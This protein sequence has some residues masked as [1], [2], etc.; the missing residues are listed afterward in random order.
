VAKKDSKN[1]KKGKDKGRNIYAYYVELES[2][3]DLVRQAFSYTTGNLKAIK[4][5][6]KYRLLS[7][8]ERLG[9]I[10]MVYFVTLDSIGNFFVYYPGNADSKERF[11]IKNKLLTEQT[12]YK[13]LKA[14]IVELL[15][16]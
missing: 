7:V 9:E 4:S 15:S 2:P 3:L 8:G 16:H 12:D 10:R 13:S 14:P 1:A 5:G 6:N 11:E